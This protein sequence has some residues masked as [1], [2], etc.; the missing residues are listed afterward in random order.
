MRRHQSAG[1]QAGGGQIRDPDRQIKPLLHGIDLLVAQNQLNAQVGIAR[2]ECRNGGAAE[3]ERRI[4]RAASEKLPR[5]TTLAKALK[6]VSLSIAT[7][8]FAKDIEAGTARPPAMT[9][10]TI[11]KQ[12]RQTVRNC[13]Q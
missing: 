10:S 5:S 6:L 4:S 1:D 9:L 2:H 11:H 7:A 12:Y 13:P 3:R 8:R